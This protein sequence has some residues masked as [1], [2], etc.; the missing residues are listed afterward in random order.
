MVDLIEPLVRGGLVIEEAIHGCSAAEVDALM[1]AQGVEEL[2][3]SYRQFLRCTGKDPY[4]L[5]RNDEWDHSWVLEAKEIAC[6]IVVDDYERDFEQFEKA[7]VFLTHHGYMFFYFRPEDLGLPD[8]T[9]WI[10]AGDEPVRDSGLSFNQWLRTLA[11]YLPAA[12][13]LRRELGM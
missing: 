5:S 13:E 1:D 6:E 11:D 10:F 2:P 4:W 8:P 7:F 3:A 12:I 9:F